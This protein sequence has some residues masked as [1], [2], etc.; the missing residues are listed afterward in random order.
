[1]SQPENIKAVQVIARELLIE[2]VLRVESIDLLVDVADGAVLS[3]EYRRF[4][5]LFVGA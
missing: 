4:K 2:R 3:Q 1:M 5:N